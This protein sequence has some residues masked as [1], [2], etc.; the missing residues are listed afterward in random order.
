MSLNE[1]VSPQP[2]EEVPTTSEPVNVTPNNEDNSVATSVNADAEEQGNEQDNEHPGFQKRINQLLAKNRET[3]DQLLQER[4][5]REAIER[6]M[7]HF[8]RNDDDVKLSDLDSSQLRDFI[9]KARDNVEMETYIPEAQDLL[10]EKMVDEKLHKFQDDRGVQDLQT[11]GQNL[12]NIMLNNLGGERLR[13][14]ES[15]YFQSVQGTLNDLQS[16]KFKHVNTNQ[17]LAVALAEN[18]R[19]KTLQ[20]GPTLPEKVINNRSTTNTVLSNNRSANYGGSGLGDILKDSGGRLTKS[21]QG[22]KGSLN[23]AIM[24]LTA[25]KSI[26]GG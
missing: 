2:V 6:N 22:E 20:N 17:L 1:L 26:Q 14:T 4:S 3:E 18:S 10:V 25:V 9:A 7:D 23:K 12:T 16:D 24:E 19:L 11:E 15:D 21:L 13:D 5:A 8:Q